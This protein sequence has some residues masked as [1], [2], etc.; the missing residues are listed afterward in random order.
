[1]SVVSADMMGVDFVARCLAGRKKGGGTKIITKPQVVNMKIETPTIQVPE[2]VNMTIP[3]G[4]WT[5]DPQFV[6]GDYI[7]VTIGHRSF[8]SKYN[9]HD[10]L[11]IAAPCNQKDYV[12][13]P[14]DYDSYLAMVYIFTT[15]PDEATV[16]C[17]LG[18]AGRSIVSVPYAG[19]T[20]YVNSLNYAVWTTGWTLQDYVDNTSGCVAYPNWIQGTNVTGEPA[21]RL[22]ESSMYTLLE[23]M[24]VREV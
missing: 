12:E 19:Q 16:I 7:S 17:S 6:K 11:V 23:Y 15:Y 24:N 5:A 10:C 22:T 21:V 20:W 3:E 1:M 14:T 8:H 2:P 18:S 13:N 4:T 9:M